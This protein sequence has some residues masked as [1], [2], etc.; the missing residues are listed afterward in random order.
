MQVGLCPGARHL[1]QI[2]PNLPLPRFRVS[3][4]EHNLIIV[5]S[6]D[7]APRPILIGRAGLWP[8]VTDVTAI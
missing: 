8:F 4:S 1:A 7:M 6:E 3:F 2:L 5:D